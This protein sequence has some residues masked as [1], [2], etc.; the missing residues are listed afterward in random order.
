MVRRHDILGN[1]GR[2]L[3]MLVKLISLPVFFTLTYTGCGISAA[4]LTEASG[5]AQE[6][7]EFALTAVQDAF[8]KDNLP[9]LLRWYQLWTRADP[10]DDQTYLN[11]VGKVLQAQVY[12]LSDHVVV[13]IPA[14]H[15]AFVYERV[16]DG[17]L[18]HPGEVSWTGMDQAQDLSQLL[19]E[20]PMGRARPLG[21]FKGAIKY[22]RGNSPLMLL[23]SLPPAYET[24]NPSKDG[25]LD[26]IANEART[27]ARKFYDKGEEIS[28]TIPNFDLGE[29]QIWVMM[30]GQKDSGMVISIQLS[31]NPS[32]E[33]AFMNVVDYDISVARNG[34]KTDCADKIRENSLK[35]IRYV[36]G[37]DSPAA[38]PDRP[39][40][41]RNSQMKGY[42]I[43]R[44]FPLAAQSVSVSDGSL[45]WKSAGPWH[46][47]VY[48]ATYDHDAACGAYNYIVVLQNG[49]SKPISFSLK[50]DDLFGGTAGPRGWFNPH[51]QDV[52]DFMASG[53]FVGRFSRLAPGAQGS[54]T[55][56]C[57]FGTNAITLWIGLVSFGEDRYSSFGPFAAPK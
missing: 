27:A 3:A 37:S 42:W 23:S 49:Y 13:F 1:Q 4:S 36:I 46:K 14:L 57:R 34:I 12:G 11:H 31:V 38:I 32:G 45:L 39:L 19:R 43:P 56:K 26:R 47:L 51:E 10:F 5:G 33:P 55:G 20:P 48:R 8:L 29:P 2:H 6:S 25:L 53:K 28:I 52:F 16:P 50:A 21:N 44:P 17:A 22:W 41:G 9:K 15:R 24:M 7:A 40:A 18:T 30:K 35:T 54:I